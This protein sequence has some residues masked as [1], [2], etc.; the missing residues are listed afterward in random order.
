MGKGSHGRLRHATPL[1]TRQQQHGQASKVGAQKCQRAIVDAVEVALLC[2]VPV[3]VQQRGGL[4]SAGAPAGADR[5]C[6][7]APSAFGLPRTDGQFDNR[8]RCFASERQRGRPRQR[9]AARSRA[10]AHL[11]HQCGIAQFCCASMVSVAICRNR[12]R[13]GKSGWHLQLQF[14][15][16]AAA[17]LCT[18]SAAW[19]GGHLIG[20][21]MPWDAVPLVHRCIVGLYGSPL[22]N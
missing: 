1:R 5:W 16:A 21:P 14:T 19:A 17:L 2:L 18:P 15:C 13:R 20:R 11:C 4:V 12:G 10:S 6:K 8:H 3:V 9:P 7:L 22:S